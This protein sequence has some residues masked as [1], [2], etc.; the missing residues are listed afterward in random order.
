MPRRSPA[1]SGS[2][3]RV[4]SRGSE[5][6]RALLCLLVAGCASHPAIDTTYES[7]SQGSRVRFLV[8]HYTEADFPSALKILTEG[9][10]SAHY[11]VRDDPPTVYRLVDE[12]RRA[13]HA[14]DSSWQGSTE[15]N[16]ASI[17]IEIVNRGYRAD[18]GTWQE[19]PE[20]QI[21]IVLALAKDIAERHSIPPDR[22]VGHSDIAPQRKIDP[23][24][25][26][27]WKRFADAGLIRWPDPA[28]VARRLPAFGARLPD[29]AWFQQALETFGYAVPR[30]GELDEATVHVIAAFQMRH[31]PSRYD[32]MPDAETAA[33]L[34]VLVNP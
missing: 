28:E 13:F 18:A 24:P 22:V 33:I 10:V 16:S 6:R 23:G 31:R 34:D 12:N 1:T 9:P 14:G 20:K 15:V 25:R 32:G 29:V 2:T 27:P 19:Y 7:A 3:S 21:E 4:P 17:G 5:I 8:L 26:F 11:L 30:N